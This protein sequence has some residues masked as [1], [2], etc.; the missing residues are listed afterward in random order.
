[1]STQPV[2]VV[3]HPGGVVELRLDDPGRGNALDLPTAEALR[4]RTAEVAADPGGAVLLRAS[5]STFCVGGDL[6]AFA[7]R[8]PA[9]GEYVHA[10]ATAAH[11]AVAALYELPVPVV[12]AVRGAA[13]G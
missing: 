1:M 3:R 9:T 2:R 13:A 8:G 12:T 7:G 5:G 10:V 11:A 6:R 4:D